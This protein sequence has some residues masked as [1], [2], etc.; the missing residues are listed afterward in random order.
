MTNFT[1]HTQERPLGFALKTPADILLLLPRVVLYVF[2]TL[3]IWQ[4]RATER[5]HLASLSDRRLQDMG[6]TRGD[7]GT[8]IAKPFWRA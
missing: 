3:L 5:H 6:L 8:E 1:T 7:I 4:E 2:N